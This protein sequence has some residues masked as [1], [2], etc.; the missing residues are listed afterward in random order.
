MIVKISKDK[1]SRFLNI[2]HFVTMFGFIIS[3]LLSF[4]LEISIALIAAVLFVQALFFLVNGMVLLIYKRGYAWSRYRI[5]Y[6]VNSAAVSR[7]R[8]EILL[9][10]I[11]WGIDLYLVLYA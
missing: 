4:F 9:A 10:M 7:G 1:L 8:V 5:D 11:I 2:A 3:V 6:V